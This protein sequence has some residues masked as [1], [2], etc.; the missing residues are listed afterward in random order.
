MLFLCTHNSARSILAEAI[1]NHLGK[2]K[3]KAYSAGTNPSK[4][5]ENTIKV[6]QEV[7]IPTEYLYSKEIDEFL[8]Q[9]FDYVITTCDDAKENCPY[10]PNADNRI[11]WS[12]NDPSDVEGP[13]EKKLEAF[14]ATREEINKRIQNLLAKLEI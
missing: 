11:H 12:L 2:G 13:D 8:S 5:K 14:R 3:I 7:G 6:L 4:V 9:H 1:A 10:F